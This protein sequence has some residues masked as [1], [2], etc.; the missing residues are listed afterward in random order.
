MPQCRVGHRLGNDDAHASVVVAVAV[1][2]RT[3]RLRTGVCAARAA[4]GVPR[5]TGWR[6]HATGF[7]AAAAVRAARERGRGA[8]QGWQGHG[9]RHQPVQADADC[10]RGDGS[11]RSR[12][13]R[14]GAGRCRRAGVSGRL[15]ATRRRRLR[16]AGGAGCQPRLQLFRTRRG[17]PGQRRDRGAVQRRHRGSH[18]APDACVGGQPATLDGAGSHAGEGTRRFRE[19]H[20]GRACAQPAAR[21]RQPGLDGILGTIHPHQGLGA[22]ATE[23]RQGHARALPHRVH[24]PRLRRQPRLPRLQGH[25]RVVEHGGR[26]DAP[27]DLGVPRR[28]HRDRHPRVRRLGEQRAVGHRADHRGDSVPGIALPHGRESQRA[29]PHRSFVRRL[30]HAV[31]AGALSGNLRRHLVHLARLQRLPRFHRA[32]PVRA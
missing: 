22:A 29:L 23:L 8:G 4:P 27:D 19:G 14:F 28:T 10:S 20:A 30:G 5:H 12:T 25:R 24:D 3:A 1:V 32:G 21:L 16:H 6:V 9:H 7:R 31:A 2:R 11:D 15:F 13:G 18:A 17:R 26:Q